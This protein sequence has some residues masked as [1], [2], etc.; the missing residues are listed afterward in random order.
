MSPSR[1][2]IRVWTLLLGAILVAAGLFGCSLLEEKLDRIEQAAKNIDSLARGDSARLF[3]PEASDHQQDSAAQET[4]SPSE[5]PWSTEDRSA[6][7]KPST[8]SPPAPVATSSPPEPSSEVG[9]G[10]F[11]RWSPSGRYVV[12]AATQKGTPGLRIVRMETGDDWFLPFAWE[13]RWFPQG[14]RLVYVGRDTAQA[15]TRQLYVF[16]LTSGERRP[17]TGFPNTEK[18][19]IEP[20]I[21][22]RGQRVAFVQAGREGGPEVHL[23]DLERRRVWQLTEGRGTIEHLRWGPRGKQLSLIRHPSPDSAKTV[24][25]EVGTGKTWPVAGT[26]RPVP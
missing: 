24:L 1:P 19:P 15:P 3:S 4:P 22:P 6:N 20:A 5:D 7:D 14:G 25:V 21:G 13:G 23:M 26:A 17:L 10:A 2:N 11:L 18:R 16:D 8:D 12:T 9:S